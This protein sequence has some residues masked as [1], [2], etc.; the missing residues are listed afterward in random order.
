MPNTTTL[1]DPR[2][3]VQSLPFLVFPTDNS[4][5]KLSIL[6]LLPIDTLTSSNSLG[7]SP[8]L[9]MPLFIDMNCSTVGFSFTCN[10]RKHL[11]YARA[12]SYEDIHHLS[13]ALMGDVK[14]IAR[15]VCSPAVIGEW[16]S[17][18]RPTVECKGGCKPPER[19]NFNQLRLLLRCHTMQIHVSWLTQGYENWFRDMFHW[20]KQVCPT[21]VID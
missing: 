2:I 7:K 19:I 10:I 17:P 5:I 13:S 3:I 20:E 14:W 8:P 4:I 12:S 16:T 18:P 15:Y 1:P 21:D 6:I 11:D 9:L